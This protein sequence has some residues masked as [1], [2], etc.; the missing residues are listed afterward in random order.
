MRQTENAVDRSE[1][2]QNAS[3]YEARTAVVAGTIR[4][5]GA[6]TRAN[7]RVP[8]WCCAE[9]NIGT[10]IGRDDDRS[11]TAGRYTRPSVGMADQRLVGVKIG[12]GMWVRR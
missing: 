2:R 3:I 8:I 4:K 6:G 12:R 11:P 10:S 1:L 5:D 7:M 9:A